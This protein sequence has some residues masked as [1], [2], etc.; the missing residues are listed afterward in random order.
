MLLPLIHSFSIVF[1]CPHL[2][3]LD[4]EAGA[5]Q[6]AVAAPLPSRG[7]AQHPAVRP[8]HGPARLPHHLL[9]GG[10][11]GGTRQEGATGGRV[12]GHPPVQRPH[13]GHGRPLGWDSH[14]YHAG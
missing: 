13:D 4:L 3:F 6:C 9:P 5:Q 11:Q 1:F 8:E 10:P 2:F 14:G 7:R 12:P